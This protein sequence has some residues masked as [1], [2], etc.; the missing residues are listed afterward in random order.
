MLRNSFKAWYFD[1]KKMVITRTVTDYSVN[2]H[3]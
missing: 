1:T 3:F 2:I